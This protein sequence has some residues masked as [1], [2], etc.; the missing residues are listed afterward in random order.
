MAA[1]QLRCPWFFAGWPWTATAAAWSLI[2]AA[3]LAAAEAPAHDAPVDAPVPVRAERHRL[4][5]R[6]QTGQTVHYETVHTSTLTTRKSQVAETAHNESRTR[7]HYRVVS[8]DG[9]GSAL[10]ELTLDRVEMTAR[11]GDAPPLSLDSDRPREVPPVYRGV[12]KTVGKPLARVRMSA[13]GKLLS[14]ES[15]LS[16][17]VEAEVSG[18]PAPRETDDDDPNKNFLVKFPA[19]PLA[20]GDEWTDSFTVPVFVTRKLT[21]DVKILRKYKLD[22]V[23]GTTARISVAAAVVTPLRDPAISAQL[24]QREPAGVIEFDLKRGVI[25]SRL[26][27]SDKTVLAPFG[28]DTSMHA[29]SRLTETLVEGDRVA[30]QP[31]R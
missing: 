11:F 8:V 21:R 18:L 27:T 3:G 6:F 1:A 12:V 25:V 10:L 14:S 2:A 28:D 19:E 17:E 9:D 23:E 20:V 22:A 30:Q 15:L 31:G 26:L 4:A 13:T 16:R 5:Y 24:I 7:K 29:E